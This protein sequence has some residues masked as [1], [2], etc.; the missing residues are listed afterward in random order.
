VDHADGW[1]TRPTTIVAILALALGLLVPVSVVTAP[2]ADA[3]SAAPRALVQE[4]QKLRRVAQRRHDAYRDVREDPRL[5]GLPTGVATEI[6]E[7]ARAGQTRITD[8]VLVAEGA[9]KVKRVR[10]LRQRIA[11]ESAA[12]LRARIAAEVEKQR[13]DVNCGPLGRALE[14]S[15]EGLLG[16]VVRLVDTL[17]L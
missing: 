15:E 17:C 5:P 10:T 11:D 14:A 2:G 12:P 7:A 13:Q 4:K 1:R 3:A 8:R 16:P 9:R 6:S